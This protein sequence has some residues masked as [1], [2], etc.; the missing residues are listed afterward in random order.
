MK[1]PTAIDRRPVFLGSWTAFAKETEAKKG[2][3]RPKRV[4]RGSQDSAKRVPR[5]PREGPRSPP[6]GPRWLQVDMIL[7]APAPDGPKMAA[8]GPKDVPRRPEGRQD[9]PKI[10]RKRAQD[11]A[12]V[13]QDGAKTA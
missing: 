7:K 4:P 2:P 12:K 3:R 13:A 10:V 1:T 8:R 5:G 9:G 6:K 11:G